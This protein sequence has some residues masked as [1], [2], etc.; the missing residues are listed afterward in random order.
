MNRQDAKKLAKATGKPQ[1]VTEVE[2]VDEIKVQLSLR[3]DL[4][5][6][7]KIKKLATEQGLPYTTL[8]N[9]MLKQQVSGDQALIARVD[10]IEKALK[11]G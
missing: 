5:V 3:V 2:Q 10:R 6:L 4:D 11:L 8:M 1:R 7:N 9:S